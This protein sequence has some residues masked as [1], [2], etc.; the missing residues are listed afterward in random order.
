MHQVPEA[1]HLYIHDIIKIQP[2]TIQPKKK[3]N[4]MSSGEVGGK[5][6]VNKGRSS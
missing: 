4:R 2:N 1:Q 5:G 6:V 3:D